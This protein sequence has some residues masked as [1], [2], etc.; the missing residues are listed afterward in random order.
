MLLFDGQYINVLILTNKLFIHRS[1]CLCGNQQ[2]SKLSK[3]NDT[4]S[5]NSPC[6][7]DT[8]QFCGGVWKMGIYST[9]ITGYIDYN[10]L[11]LNNCH[12]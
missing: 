3:I 11:K 4:N 10:C 5:C 12:V 9:G 7:G 6:S 2:P 1:E 8:K